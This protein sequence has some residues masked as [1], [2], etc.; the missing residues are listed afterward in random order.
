MALRK[1]SAAV[2][3]PISLA[4]IKLHL[5]VDSSDE[6]V[7]IAELLRAAREYV[8]VITN[9]QMMRAI[10]ELTTDS[11]RDPFVLPRPPLRAVTS[12]TYVDA[13]GTTQTMDSDDYVVDTRLEPG[14]VRLAYGASWPT[15][16]GFTDDIKITYVAGYACE[17]SANVITNVLTAV[18]HGYSAAEIVRFWT[19]GGTLPTPL[20]VNTNYYIRSPA[21]STF[22]VSLTAV[23]LAVDL[24]VAEVAPV[25]VGEVPGP[26]RTAIKLLTAHLFENREAVQGEGGNM[27][28]RELPFSVAALTWP[29]R[30]WLED[31]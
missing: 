2:A 28:A 19:V 18:N 9:R 23:G 5:R 10:Y 3:E 27:S 21:T 25:Y 8:E 26:L 31:Y 1:T 13:A 17:V 12:I 30:V 14:Q 16:R 6:N 11:F 22:E 29:Y 20:A 7:L 15:T 4:E 24:L